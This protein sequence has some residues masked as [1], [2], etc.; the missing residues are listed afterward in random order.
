MGLVVPPLLV[1]LIPL[2]ALTSAA[3]DSSLR[4][5]SRFRLRFAGFAVGVTLPEVLVLLGATVGMVGEQMVIPLLVGLFWDLAVLALAPLLLFYGP[6]F[7]PG[8]SDDDDGSGPGDGRPSPTPPIGGLPLPDAQQSA[9]RLRG[10]RRWRRT[11]RSRRRNREP[12][13]RPVRAQQL[14]G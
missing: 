2:G 5:R 14:S 7:D 8:P 3:F 4:H 11:A 10:P 12:A 13:H 1:A 9:M 6:G